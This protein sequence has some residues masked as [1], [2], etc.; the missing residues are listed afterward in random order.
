[1]RTHNTRVHADARSS[2]PSTVRPSSLSSCLSRP[3]LPRSK[4]PRSPRR[5]PWARPASRRPRRRP[6]AT[7]SS[8]R[9]RSSSGR[10]SGSR[11]SRAATAARF[12]PRRVDHRGASTCARATL[13]SLQPATGLTS[14]PRDPRRAPSRTSTS[15]TPAREQGSAA[16]EISLRLSDE[17]VTRRGLVPR[18][19][20]GVS[21]PVAR[22]S[23]SL[24]Q[25]LIARVAVPHLLIHPVRRRHPRVQRID[26]QSGA[27]AA[28]R[29]HPWA[30]GRSWREQHPT[31]RPGRPRA[32]RASV[33][34]ASTCS[35]GHHKVF[36]LGQ[37]KRVCGAGARVA[38]SASTEGIRE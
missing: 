16:R 8:R 4:P 35:R 15:S 22:A 38:A 3:P 11:M 32:A 12:P 7:P 37:P 1:M 18:S 28:R 9:S 19:G 25:T 23:R 5:P 27:P 13:P 33:A 17:C 30:E 6:R 29:P 14:R 10:S 36:I 20:S 2:S 26:R 21:G 34:Q 31:A 24:Q